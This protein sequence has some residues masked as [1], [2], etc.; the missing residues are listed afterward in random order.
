MECEF[1]F[2]KDSRE[3]EKRLFNMNR[4]MLWGV[5]HIN[6]A[7]NQGGGQM[8]RWGLI[9]LLVLLVQNFAMANTLHVPS[10]WYPTIQNA[11]DAA[12]DGDK[13]VIA[14]G[15]YRTS[16][17]FL[18]NKGITITG[19]NPDDPNVVA[20]TII[21]QEAGSSGW[22]ENAFLFG[23]DSGNARLEGI[24]IKG[25]N[26]RGSDGDNPT[27]LPDGSQGYSGT[28]VAGSAI[29]CVEASPTI[30]DCVITDCSATGGN[31]DVGIG[32]GTAH[33]DGG[34]GGSPGGAYGGGLYLYG[35]SPTVIN[36]TFN[37]CRVAGGTGGNGGNG[38]RGVSENG[39]PIS[40]IGGTGGGWEE[41]LSSGLG[42][43]VFVDYGSYP[44]FHGCTFSNNFSQG[45]RNGISG[46]NEGDGLIR[47]P[48]VSYKI[49][50][51]GGAVYCADYAKADFNDCA[52][53]NNEADSSGV[54]G[55]DDFISFGGAVAWEYDSRV[56]FKN[57]HFTNNAATIGGAM[58]WHDTKSSQRIDGCN[59]YGNTAFHGGGMY[60]FTSTP[61]I[62]RS[63]FSA[64]RAIEE[65]GQGGG[66]YCFDADTQITDCNI[67]G[68]DANSSG[69]GVYI[70][71]W[72]KPVLL[73]NCLITNNSAGRDGGGVSADWITFYLDIKNCTIAN[74]VVTGVGFPLGSYG[75]GLYTAYDSDARI[76]DSIIWG[77]SAPYGNQIAIDTYYG[78]PSSVDVDYS[79][80]QGGAVNVFVDSGS[81]LTWR[82][83]NLN[84]V[85]LDPLF[86]S[87]Y[88]GSYYLSQEAAGQDTN[89]PCVDTG[90]SDADSAGMY[91]H[92]TRTDHIAE[93][94]D[95]VVDMGY[96]FVLPMDAL[97]GCDF[98]FDGIVDMNDLE[99][100]SR[101]YE[102]G[103]PAESGCEFPD[104]CNGTDL[105]KDGLVNI[106]DYGI[107]ARHFKEQDTT[108]PEPNPMTW[109]VAPRSAGA[110][111][112]TMTA[113]TAYDSSTGRFVQYYFEASGG[114]HS[115]GWQDSP[116]YTDTVATGVQ[117]GYKVKARDT[118]FGYN[119]TEWSHIGY[120]VAGEAGVTLPAAPTNLAAT[121][122][123]GSRIDLA[124]TDMSDNE[125]GF[126][127]DRKSGTDAF[128][129][130]A[131]VGANVNIYSD[132]GLTPLTA[133]TYRVGAF[134]S[135]GVSGYSNEASAT[136]LEVEDGN[137]GNEPVVDTTPPEPNHSQWA[138]EP[139]E[140]GQLDPNTGMFWY[141]HRME[142]V[143]T[144]DTTTGG[145]NPCEYYF[146]YIS[147]TGGKDSSWQCCPIYICRV[148]IGPTTCQYR[149]RARDAK[150]N[151]TEWSPTRSSH[152][153]P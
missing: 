57:C 29:A 26:I 124:W 137:D 61:R 151:T 82:D 39:D 33:P 43:A 104:W 59:F 2:D 134:N 16:W 85:A 144:D 146:D 131:T 129:Q 114:G 78:E 107:F 117:C 108:A 45:G 112:I 98:T 37:N 5:F 24:T 69:G 70:A 126:R 141:Y 7:I 12:S 30:R 47:E 15:T 50:T 119:E 142:A 64:N 54:G 90:S 67:S 152:P 66:I 116:T 23:P 58:F 74:N 6:G 48:S 96:H 79:A 38:G 10:P 71:S 128:S 4:L 68:N 113:T 118:S 148:G 136:T 51:L 92:T 130:I 62:A 87:G 25:F 19:S 149:V 17:G 127:I 102:P 140:F 56:I 121:A 143:V 132:T 135:A 36:C 103:E 123:S 60:F 133:Y 14:P 77:N 111:S 97:G 145:N 115:N 147:G 105:N 75:G 55:P 8:K 89:S 44:K 41:T 81:T 86:V 109:A 110:T 138:V 73:R 72:G 32:G 40:G 95:S 53:S 122:A 76:I 120:A 80:V 106:I 1:V 100:F 27:G 46:T 28:S 83:F 3:T 20:A 42:G 88:G 99:I 63:N 22:V 153:L 9:S 125:T 13:V 65:I 21:T 52:F 18:V 91:R 139:Y 31:G 150:G 84:N 11:L 34:R 94:F 101:H 49:D 93:Q 35:S